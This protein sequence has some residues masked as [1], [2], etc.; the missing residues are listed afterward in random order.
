MVRLMFS[1]LCFLPLS[2]HLKY[3][4]IIS[5][6][7]SSRSRIK[8][9]YGNQSWTIYCLLKHIVKEVTKK[10]PSASFSWSFTTSRHQSVV[11]THR[12]DIWTNRYRTQP[13]APFVS[14]SLCISYFTAV[15]NR[16]QFEFS[17]IVLVECLDV[18]WLGTIF[19]FTDRA[20]FNW[21]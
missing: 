19:S 12:T 4:R 14:G 5:C 6:K 10:G 13:L 9:L 16:V 15:N 11:Y 21:A 1:E 3:H 18:D 8:A 7:Q 17:L 20:I 2:Q